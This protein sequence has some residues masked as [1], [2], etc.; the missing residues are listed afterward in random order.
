MI[1]L[2]FPAIKKWNLRGEKFC[3]DKNAI[4]FRCDERT[5]LKL[6][7][8]KKFSFKT[9]SLK[10]K[11]RRTV[12]SLNSNIQR[13]FIANEKPRKTFSFV[14]KKFIDVC[15]PE[16]RPTTE[17]QL[18]RNYLSFLSNLVF[19]SGAG[20]S[21]FYLRCKIRLSA[22]LILCRSSCFSLQAVYDSDI[23]H[24]LVENNCREKRACYWD[25]QAT[26]RNWNE[27]FFVHSINYF[28]IHSN[29]WKGFEISRDEL[30]F[31]TW[32]EEVSLPWPSFC[33]TIIYWQIFM[34]FIFLSNAKKKLFTKRSETITS[35]GW[36]W[37][38]SRIK[39]FFLYLTRLNKFVYF[40]MVFIVS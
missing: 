27:T 18:W 36:S 1:C 32:L 31:K 20:I 14:W 33:V 35:Q 7:R 19:I 15:A 2:K 30:P 4:W 22:R 38:L 16:A 11:Q 21:Q 40:K 29:L 10:R 34:I 39:A 23:F 24:P 12:T 6:Q 3:S 9:K 28:V 25:Y 37:I 8:T 13:G 5:S 26:K 17:F